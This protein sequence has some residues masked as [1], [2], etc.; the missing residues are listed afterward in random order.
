MS[1]DNEIKINQLYPELNFVFICS[2]P[3]IIRT[4]CVKMYVDNKIV[5]LTF[6]NKTIIL[7]RGGL[8]VKVSASRHKDRG[9]EPHQ[10]HDHVFP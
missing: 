8:V 5:K 9:F 10:G 7:G 6:F 4:V 3:G 2:Q 1:T